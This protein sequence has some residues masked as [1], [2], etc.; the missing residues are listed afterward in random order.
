MK[1]F[2]TLLM[3]IVMV[4]S[5]FAFVG[6]GPDNGDDASKTHLYVANYN[7]GTG[8]A[9]LTE[10][11]ARFEKKYEN[12]SFEPGKTGVVIHDD[13]DKDYAGNVIATKLSSDTNH[14]YFTNGYNY[15]VQATTNSM[16]DI[17]SLVTETE[18]VD[19]GKTIA[20]KLD[21][22][23]V[24]SLTVNDKIYAIP[25]NE[26]YYSG[27]T[28]NAWLWKE[29]NLYFSNEGNINPDEPRN[30]VVGNFEQLSPG[31]DGN[32]LTVYDNGLPS[33]IEELNL[34]IEKMRGLG[35]I[36]F[37]WTGKSMHYSNMLPGA[38]I[39]SYLGK[40]AN[41]LYDFNSKGNNVEVVTGFSGGEPVI[42]SY[43]ISL[44]NGYDV[45][46][47]AA[48]Y[49]ATEFA[50]NIFAN[51]S[52]IYYPTYC[53]ATTYSN[54][55]AMR[56][57]IKSGLSG[58]ADDPHIA[59][60]I[61]GSYWYNEAEEARLFSTVKQLYPGVYE[62]KKDIRYMPLPSKYSGTVVEGQGSSSVV[63]DYF[64]SFAF[65]NAT[66]PENL[67]NVAETFLSFCYSDAELVNFTKTTNLVKSVNYDF[68]SIKSGLNSYTQSILNFRESAV[69]GNTFFRF[70]DKST[71]AKNSF[72][73]SLISTSEFWHYGG[74]YKTLYAAAKA[75]L[76]AKDWFE[77]VS[78]SQS[79]WG[80]M[81]N[82]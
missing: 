6:C 3:T 80:N 44:D 62:A 78:I 5:T 31:P 14:V 21:T 24:D 52:G 29:H 75:G 48:V 58:K 11:K 76:S 32:L 13:S 16:R 25:H 26:F 28:Y 53:T 70:N 39:Q 40:N 12:E 63:T 27:I 71:Y 47:T 8:E 73:L 19:D 56:D 61:D 79:E 9:W 45:K 41:I 33:S 67:V 7:G 66:I 54:T 81:I 10:A 82:N 1:K 35:I 57:F 43:P 49:Y 60:L 4:V 59:M 34:L 72:N 68:S 50:T 20:S 38:M 23:V 55:D 15:Y 22:S 18:N 17:T 37:V 36:P 51:G 42:E 46:S 74:S 65:I 69:S 2:I 30:F 64:D 77:G